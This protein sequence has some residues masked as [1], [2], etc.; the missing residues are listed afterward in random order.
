MRDTR[1]HFINQIHFHLRLLQILYQIITTVNQ[2]GQLTTATTFRL[3]KNNSGVSTKTKKQEDKRAIRNTR[4]QEDKRASS[5]TH[6]D[7]SG[8]FCF[9]H[10]LTPSFEFGTGCWNSLLCF[11]STA[12]ELLE[13]KVTSHYI[14]RAT[15]SRLLLY[16]I[17][18]RNLLAG[19]STK[20]RCV[21]CTLIPGIWRTEDF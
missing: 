10:S 21:W 11:L 5:C 15:C 3:S 14:H 2:N 4:K 7:A 1:W 19:P 6:R 9:W 18:K 20:T 17:A 13:V 16:Y 12:R 8:A